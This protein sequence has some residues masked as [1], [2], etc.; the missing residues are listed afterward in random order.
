MTESEPSGTCMVTEC[1]ARNASTSA[2]DEAVAVLLGFDWLEDEVASFLCFFLSL[3]ELPASAS[4]CSSVG[5]AASGSCLRFFLSFLGL[6][7]L[8]LVCGAS[9]D[10]GDCVGSAISPSLRRFFL[11][12]LEVL[13]SDVASSSS[14]LRFFFFSLC[15]SALLSD[16][17]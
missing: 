17:R 15:V 3:F 2:D 9:A 16:I 14:R 5:S 13:A 11:S 4:A 1:F 7:G 6:E 10:S 8:G 12:F